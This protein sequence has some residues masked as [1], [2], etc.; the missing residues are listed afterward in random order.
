VGSLCYV[1][2]FKDS[3]LKAAGKIIPGITTYVNTSYTN[4]PIE[5][6]GLIG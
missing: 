5:D 3:E 1:G 4:P 2:G 6:S